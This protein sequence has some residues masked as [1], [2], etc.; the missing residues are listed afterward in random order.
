MLNFLRGLFKKK[1]RD[2]IIPSCVY[3]CLK[4]KCPKWVVLTDTIT[5]EGGGEEKKLVGR[6][7]DAWQV[8]LMVEIIQA[9]KAR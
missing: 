4:E 2:V 9:L 3:N 1:E 5:L 8:Y 6:C 7:A